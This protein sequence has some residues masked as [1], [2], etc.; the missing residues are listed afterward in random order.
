MDLIKDYKFF[1][2]NIEDFCKKY[3]NKF[4]VIQNKQIL[5]IYNSFDEARTTTNK[6]EK[7]GTYLIQKCTKEGNSNPQ[8]FYSYQL[9]GV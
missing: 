4:I 9:M 3:K 5:G 8:T 1:M 6:T 7:E 2:E